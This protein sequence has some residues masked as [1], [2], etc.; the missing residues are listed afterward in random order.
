MRS[1]CDICVE[2]LRTDG[3]SG[4]EPRGDIQLPRNTTVRVVSAHGP[5]TEVEWVG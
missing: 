1:F 5:Q 4:L 3:Y 2:K